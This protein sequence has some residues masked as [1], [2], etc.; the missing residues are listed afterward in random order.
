MKDII[1]AKLLA[2]HRQHRRLVLF[3]KS[4][5][6]SPPDWYFSMKYFVN[7]VYDYVC[8]MQN[9]GYS[10]EEIGFDRVSPELGVDPDYRFLRNAHRT[11][12]YF[13]EL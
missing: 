6:I 4:L 9:A 1:F 7:R 12:L 11:M 3:P 8:A 5:R 10:L 2:I 13:Q